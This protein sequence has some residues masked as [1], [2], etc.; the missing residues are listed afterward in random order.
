[1]LIFGASGDLVHKKTIPA[2]LS[3]Y[4]TSLARDRISIVG[5]ARSRLDSHGWRKSLLSSQPPDADTSA[6][7]ERCFYTQVSSYSLSEGEVKEVSSMIN[8]SER[9][10]AIEERG[11]VV[12]L[13]VPPNL[14]A[15]CTLSAARL[16]AKLGS[17]RWARLVVEKPFGRD[18]PSAAALERTLACG[19][20][21]GSVFRI[22]HF[23]AKHLVQSL[24]VLRF[25]NALLEPI[26][27]RHNVAA[28]LI[29]AK[30]PFGVRGRAGYFD[31]A[32]IVRDM[33]QLHLLN[34]ACMVLM[35]RPT[36]VA[37]DD[38]HA[39]RLNALRSIRPLRPFDY[40]GGQ[41]EGY[42]A[43]P[44]VPAG[45]RCATFAS[46]VLRPASERWAGVPFILKAGKSVDE[47]KTEIR[48][49]FAPVPPG[50]GA[51]QLCASR[52]CGECPRNELVIRIQP[53][54]AIYYQLSVLDPS[55]SATASLPITQAELDLEY[56]RR[57]SGVRLPDAYEALLNDCIG[58]D[59]SNFVRPEFIA[60]SWRLFD[61]LLESVE[62]VD[63]PPP[64]PYAVGSRGPAAADEL[65]H[66]EGYARL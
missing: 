51:S 33:I 34:A 21:R 62:A 38:I 52:H 57:F 14:F 48:I 28:V 5:L 56:E 6:F 61:P 49:Q 30:E 53:N 29:T 31:Q 64:L 41:Y 63:A 37:A 43:E 35:E 26:L 10:E 36:S 22:D 27:N 42:Q 54:P 19:W 55:A 17:G 58:G 46:V 66:R 32:G 18:G 11:T 59:D 60:A 39:A 25:A 40:V 50:V 1:V 13:A 15:E 24:M 4:R 12:Y 23:L 44:G 7:L 47:Y 8:A 20:P 3:L 45:S 9:C 2:L 65:A 16:C